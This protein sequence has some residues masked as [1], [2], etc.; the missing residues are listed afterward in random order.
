MKYPPYPISNGLRRSILSIFV[1]VFL[2]TAPGL[3]LYTAGYKLDIKHL[4]FIKNGVLSVD[5]EPENVQ[6]SLGDETLIYTMPLRVPNLSPGTYHLKIE[7]ENYYTWEKDI[8]I[9]EN[10]T[11]YI[12]DLHL[13]E[14]QNLKFLSKQTPTNIY[15][16]PNGKYILE[17]TEKNTQTEYSIFDTKKQNHTKL[18]TKDTNEYFS[19]L[20]SND[21]EYLALSASFVSSSQVY[22]LRG[23]KPEVVASYEIPSSRNSYQWSE[24]FYGETFLTFS[25]SSTYHMNYENMTNESHVFVTST[26]LFRD[27][28]NKTWY[29]DSASKSLFH[30]DNKKENIYIGK[31]SIEKIIDVNESR[32]LVQANN[33]IIVIPRDSQKETKTLNTKKYFYIASKHEFLAWSSWEIWTVHE[34][35]EVLLLNRMSEEIQDVLPLDENGTLFVATPSKLVAFNPG[36]YVFTT[37]AENIRIEKISNDIKERKIYLLA[38]SKDKRGIYELD[39]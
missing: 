33:S 7:K 17:S 30:I 5:A 11:T 38:T 26:I 16:S 29:F 37:L 13:F 8:V 21:G 1:L 34:N 24:K 2:I 10:K 4:R 27:D 12:R 18:F 19:P 28:N 3:T 25:P 39:Y 9:E 20:W 32:V 6:I 15:P 22:F 31:N 23:S 36:Y 35:G 14:K